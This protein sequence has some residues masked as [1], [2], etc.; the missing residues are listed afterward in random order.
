LHFENVQTFDLGYLHCT[1]RNITL[2]MPLINSLTPLNIKPFDRPL[3]KVDFLAAKITEHS[4]KHELSYL[5]ACTLRRRNNNELVI[6]WTIIRNSIHLLLRLS[7]M[8]QEGMSYHL[9]GNELNIAFTI[10][11][12]DFAVMALAGWDAPLI[13]VLAELGYLAWVVNSVWSR[14]R[15]RLID[16]LLRLK[17]A[18]LG[19]QFEE[20][21]GRQIRLR[22]KIARRR[23][24]NF[25]GSSDAEQPDGQG[26]KTSSPPLFKKT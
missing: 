17:Y 21:L 7:K 20:E 8:T 1:S 19:R 2:I 13:P 15:C 12:I 24:E 23:S 16:E 22:A 26:T 11:I 10:D 3:S 4:E 14:R 18:L 6:N 5:A 25:V 9:R